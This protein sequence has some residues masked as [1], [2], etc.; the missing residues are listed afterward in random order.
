MAMRAGPM[1]LLAATLPACWLQGPTVID[2]EHVGP[3]GL[4]G[5]EGEI[6]GE[7]VRMPTGS[8]GYL[9]APQFWEETYDFDDLGWFVASGPPNSVPD[10]RSPVGLAFLHM[11]TDGPRASQWV[12]AGAG[13][14]YLQHADGTHE[15]YLENLS[16]MGSCIDAPPGPHASTLYRGGL[17]DG[18]YD[19][20]WEGSPE[21]NL[22][23][24][25]VDGMS[26]AEACNF[27]GRTDHGQAWAW[28][29][30]DRVEWE[31]DVPVPVEDAALLLPD[32]DGNHVLACAGS[33]SYFTQVP[34]APDDPDYQLELH[35]VSILGGCP[36]TPVDGSLV[37]RY[38]YDE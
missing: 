27:G 4:Q 38:Y 12:C 2:H 5:I 36:G 13:S 1:A 33:D 9:G 37:A 26:C 21:L 18:Y 23:G 16:I 19:D 30:P 32:P 17:E 31:D 20:S 6:D 25:Y 24:T 3:H 34:D 10:T 22:E 11:P 28:F 8:A 15:I 7:E 29:V 35:G 14:E